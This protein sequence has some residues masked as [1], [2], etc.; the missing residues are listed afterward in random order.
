MAIYALNRKETFTSLVSSDTPLNLITEFNLDEESAAKFTHLMRWDDF[1]LSDKEIW[2]EFLAILGLTPD[3]V[4]NFG[5]ATFEAYACKWYNSPVIAKEDDKLFLVIGTDD[6]EQKAVRLPVE[7]NKKT[8]DIIITTYDGR[9]ITSAYFSKGDYPDPDD[10]NKRIE[11]PLFVLVAPEE[12]RE[13]YP[14]IF[15]IRI[16]TRNKPS[17]PKDVK[18]GIVYLDYAKFELATREFNVKVLTEFIQEL[19]SFKT[20]APLSTLLSELFISKEFPNS[21]IC[22]PIYGVKSVDTEYGVSWVADTD[23]KQAWICGTSYKPL[24]TFQSWYGSKKNNTAVPVQSDKIEAI[25]I[26][27]SHTA[28]TQIGVAVNQ[29]KQ[30]SKQNPWILWISAPNISAK[31]VLKPDFVPKHQMFVSLPPIPAIKN[32]APTNLLP[33]TKPVATETEKF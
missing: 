4:P 18:E 8:K 15:N 16:N 33:A 1:S 10:Q 22:I 27:G 2:L 5:S 12:D 20:A 9:R 17:D 13:K 29:G 23:M 6:R 14:D 24:P 7:I 28:G 3:L 31:G 25:F 21:G 30:P 26:G 19:Q 11:Y 32:S